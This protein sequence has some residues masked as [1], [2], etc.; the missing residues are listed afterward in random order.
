[1]IRRLA[2]AA[3]LLACAPVSACIAGVTGEGGA[4]D[5][6]LK[7]GWISSLSGPLSSAAVAENRGVQYAVDRINADGGIDGQQIELITRDTQGDPTKAVN[8]AKELTLKDQV[9]AIIGPVNSGEGIPV[10]PVLARAD[11][12]NVVISTVDSLTSATEYP[13]AYRVIPTNEQWVTAANAYLLDKLKIDKV[14]ILSD[15]TG[16]GTETGAQAENL[17]TEAGGEV[18]YSGLIDPAQTDVSSDVRKARSSGAQAILVWSAA[19]GLDARIIDARSELGWDVPVAGHPALGAGDTGSLLSDK[20]NWDKVYAVGYRSMSRDTSNRL[21][22]RTSRFIDQAGTEVLG[23]DIDYTL[24]WVAMGYDSVE[25]LRHAIEDAGSTDPEAMSQ[26]LADTEDFAGVFGTYSWGESDRD[27][28][29]QQSVV[30]N[31]ASSFDSGT[32]RLAPGYE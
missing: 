4:D 30:L 18:T 17:F 12:P 3:C 7:I 23:D 6:V 8:A 25:V 32:F 11:T 16:Y 31:E 1:M 20:A 27:G 2:I 26:A 15:S 14:A 24:W 28:Y 10:V 19:T 21:P 13:M 29:P 9:D 22:E 5:G